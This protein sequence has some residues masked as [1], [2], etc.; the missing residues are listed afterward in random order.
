MSAQDESHFQSSL[1][2]FK[3]LKLIPSGSPLSP[4]LSELTCHDFSPSAGDMKDALDFARKAKNLI[5]LDQW[6]TSHSRDIKN[7]ANNDRRRKL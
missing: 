6:L 7:L 2:L 5:W 1:L 4:K 3:C